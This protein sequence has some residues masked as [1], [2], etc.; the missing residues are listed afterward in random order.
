M[1]IYTSF[2]RSSLGDTP[3]PGQAGKA[4]LIPSFIQISIQIVTKRFYLLFYLKQLKWHKLRILYEY[5]CAQSQY[6]TA[7]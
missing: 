4:A 1:K 3:D 5:L 6:N 7:K 2:S